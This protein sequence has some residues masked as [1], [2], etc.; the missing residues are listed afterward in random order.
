MAFS[1]FWNG[2]HML[3]LQAILGLIFVAASLP[4]KLFCLQSGTA[5]GLVT[6]NAV[7]YTLASL[8]PGAVATWSYLRRQQ[9][10]ENAGGSNQGAGDLACDL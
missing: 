5:V 9:A 3:R 2:M 7:F 1:Y 4:A 8:L 6:V 10:V